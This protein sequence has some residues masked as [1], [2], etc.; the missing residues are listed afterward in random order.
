VSASSPPIRGVVPFLAEPTLDS[1]DERSTESSATGNPPRPIRLGLRNIELRSV[2]RFDP[3][4]VSEYELLC[5]PVLQRASE[6]LRAEAVRRWDETHVSQ[7]LFAGFWYQAGTWP[8]PRWVVVK[9]EA[10]SQG[11][12]RRFVT[13]NRPGAQAYQ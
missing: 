3:E 4:S 8:H 5:N 2:L 13:T 7:R 11:T 6:S 12:N 1:P 10:N 9:P